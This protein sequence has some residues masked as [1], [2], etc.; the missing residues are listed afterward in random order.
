VWAGH[1]TVVRLAL[2][3]GAP[4]V[5]ARAAS[6]VRGIAALGGIG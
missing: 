1:S 5:P 3:L 4:D 6:P 2:P